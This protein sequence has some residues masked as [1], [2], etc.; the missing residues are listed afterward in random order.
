MFQSV[1]RTAEFIVH[2]QSSASRTSLH[3]LTVIPA[4][5]CWAIIGRPASRDCLQNFLCK[6]IRAVRLGLP[7]TL[8]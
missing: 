1:K 5:K 3:A 6:A 8:N 4:L 2:F 7:T